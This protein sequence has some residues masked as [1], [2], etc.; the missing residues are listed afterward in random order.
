MAGRED[1][2]SPALAAEEPSGTK[3]NDGRKSDSMGRGAM[4]GKF[5]GG[6]EGRG[7]KPRIETAEV[8]YSPSN[9]STAIKLL[10]LPLRACSRSRALCSLPPLLTSNWRLG[11]KAF[12]AQAP[13]T[14]PC[15]QESAD[16]T[17]AP[18]RAM[19]S[20]A[21]WRSRALAGCELGGSCPGKAPL[22]S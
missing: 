13:C 7:G 14:Q 3:G 12:Q 9:Q 17:T 1:S 19:G 22:V 5:R 18:S 11:P 15:T 4:P 16:A 10:Y 20:S 21:P 2:G 6:K 8:T